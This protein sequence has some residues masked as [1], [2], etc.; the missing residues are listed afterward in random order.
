MRCDAAEIADVL[1]A[2]AQPQSWLVLDW[3]LEAVV[4]ELV[5]FTTASLWQVELWRR[6]G[7]GLVSTCRAVSPD[8]R[9][10]EWG[11]QRRWLD[12]GSVVEPLELIGESACVALDLRL[13]DAVAKPPRDV[14]VAFLPDLDR[15]KPKARPAQ[16]RR[17]KQ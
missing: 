4:P 3:P 6:P 10:W 13:L 5:R 17:V 1:A 11:C 12:N 16:R 9:T 7:D 14:G 8:C 15:I 2:A